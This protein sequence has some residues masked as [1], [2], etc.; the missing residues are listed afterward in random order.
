MEAN[1]I[2]YA[3]Q[4]VFLV[5]NVGIFAFFTKGLFDEVSSKGWFTARSLWLNCLT[6]GV[7]IEIILLFDPRG[8]FGL[9]PPHGLKFLEWMTIISVLVGLMFT[10]YMYLIVLYRYNFKSVPVRVRAF[11][12]GINVIFIAIHVVLSAVGSLSNNLFWYGV[13]GLVLILHEDLIVLTL[14]V[15]IYK[16]TTALH[17][18]TK[19]IST[20]GGNSNFSVAIKKLRCVCIVSLVA[21]LIT[22]AYQLGAPGTLDRLKFNPQSM[23]AYNNTNFSPLT[24]VTPFIIASLYTLLLYS[25]RRPQTKSQNVSNSFSDKSTLAIHST[26]SSPSSDSAPS[27]ESQNSRLSASNGRLSPNLVRPAAMV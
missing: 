23:S 5:W 25:S 16:L 22:N 20:S 10:A 6:C 26:E 9:Y 15:S 3:V 2:Y 17:A 12:I 1:P 27:S 18:Q 24:V 14:N 19:E 7:A 4:A 11:W 8:I 21:A 13:D